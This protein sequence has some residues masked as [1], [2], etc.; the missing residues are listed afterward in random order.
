MHLHGALSPINK[1]YNVDSLLIIVVK[2]LG[3]YV[4]PAVTKGDENCLAIPIPTPT[5]TLPRQRGREIRC[6]D[7]IMLMA[8]F[9]MKYWE[10]RFYLAS[11]PPSTAIV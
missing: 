2:V 6:N 8:H 3:G 10:K 5:L 9:Q 4:W 1:L 11:H 7:F